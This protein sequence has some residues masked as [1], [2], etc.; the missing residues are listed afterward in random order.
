MLYFDHCSVRSV[1]TLFIL[2]TSPIIVSSEASKQN[3]LQCTVHTLL[4]LEVSQT[5][6][7]KNKCV[8]VFVCVFVEV[9]GGI[10]SNSL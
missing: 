3:L 7:S 8:C 4:N 10:I 5:K 1:R 6:V 2:S 9:F